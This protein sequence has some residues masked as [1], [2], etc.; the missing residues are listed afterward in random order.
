MSAFDIPAHG[1]ARHAPRQV[2]GEI[3]RGAGVAPGHAS[4]ADVVAGRT[5]QINLRRVGYVFARRDGA[6][7]GYHR[8]DIVVRGAGGQV[9]LYEEGVRRATLTAQRIDEREVVRRVRHAVKSDPRDVDV[10]LRVKR[11]ALSDVIPD[12]AYI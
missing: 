12:T 10:P 11:H 4:H 9:E 1:L 3:K 2:I 8:R 5:R 7:D 6:G